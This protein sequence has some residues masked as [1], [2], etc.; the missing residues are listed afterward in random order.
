VIYDLLVNCKDPKPS[1][2]VFQIATHLHVCLGTQLKIVI[3]YVTHVQCNPVSRS[4]NHYCNGNA[5]MC[6]AC[7][8]EQSVT[9]NNIKI[10]SVAEKKLFCSEFISPAK[11]N[12]T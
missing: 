5:T 12:H 7:I 10:L 6:S 8:A 4:T 11:I 9:V 2:N 1:R 3:Q